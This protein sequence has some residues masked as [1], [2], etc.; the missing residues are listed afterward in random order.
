[1]SVNIFSKP[2]KKDINSVRGDFLSTALNMYYHNPGHALWVAY[3][4]ALFLKYKYHDPILDLGCGDGLFTYLLFNKTDDLLFD[5]ISFRLLG[6]SPIR[7]RENINEYLIGL[8]LNCKSIIHAKR[9]GLYSL[10]ISGNACSLPFEDQSFSTVISNCS[11]AW[12][13]KADDALMEISRVLKPGGLLAFT[14]PSDQFGTHFPLGI[15]FERIKAFNLSNKYIA[16]RIIKSRELYLLP[17]SAWTNKIINSGLQIL[18]GEYYL[19]LRSATLA[20][21]LTSMNRARF[22]KITFGAILRRLALFPYLFNSTLIKYLFIQ[23]YKK[24]FSKYYHELN[25]GEKG[26]AF[27]F[28]ARKNS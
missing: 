21:S 25:Q 3:E 12:I 22:G 13:P 17:L 27:F 24:A 9:L 14:A 28:L 10:L 19:P 5:E 18:D 1:M 4:L 15:L 8:D 16:H 7:Y 11:L 2:P 23:F 20:D 26:A 6:R